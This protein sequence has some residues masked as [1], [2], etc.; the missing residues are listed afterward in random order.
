MFFGYYDFSLIIEL[1]IIFSSSIKN[2][3]IYY[4]ILINIFFVIVILYILKAGKTKYLVLALLLKIQIYSKY[5]F[6][7]NTNLY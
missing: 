3:Y 6:I 2:F 5:K 7:Q 4:F 1:L